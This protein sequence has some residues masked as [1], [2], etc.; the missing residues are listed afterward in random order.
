M[1][2][3]GNPQAYKEMVTQAQNKSISPECKIHCQGLRDLQPLS[4]HSDYS[5]RAEGRIV[6]REQRPIPSFQSVEAL[7]FNRPNA[8]HIQSQ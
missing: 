4:Q 1:S 8:I 3:G 7:N 6:S 2:E 5:S